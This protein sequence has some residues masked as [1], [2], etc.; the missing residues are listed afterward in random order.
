M[1]KQLAVSFLLVKNESFFVNCKAAAF[2]DI[3]GY[4]HTVCK[5]RNEY[6]GGDRVLINSYSV[7][8]VLHMIFCLQLLDENLVK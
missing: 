4:F 2:G 8:P 7:F 5:K 6:F 1:F 3:K